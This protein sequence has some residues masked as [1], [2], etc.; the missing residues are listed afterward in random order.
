MRD[1]KPV[2]KSVELLPDRDD[3]ILEYLAQSQI[4]TSAAIRAGLRLLIE[5]D[6][7]VVVD[8]LHEIKE[9]VS[10]LDGS[11]LK[12]KLLDKSKYNDPF[13]DQSL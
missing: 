10:S 9:I 4:N 12:P 11:S 6:T 13:L 7:I 5:N 2:V 8:L 3:D 1:K